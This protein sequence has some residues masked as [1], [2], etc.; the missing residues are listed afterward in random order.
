MCRASSPRAPVARAGHGPLP[1]ALARD[2]L[3]RPVRR[4]PVRRDGVR[5]PRRLRPPPGRVGGV[6]QPLRPGRTRV[7]LRPRPDEAPSRRRLLGGGAPRGDFA[8]T[9]SKEAGRIS[10]A[11]AAF[12]DPDRSP[13]RPR[14]RS[15]VVPPYDEWV[16]TL[17]WTARPPD[18]ALRPPGSLRPPLGGGGRHAHGVGEGAGP[19]HHHRRR[20][21]RSRSGRRHHA[22]PGR[23]P[24]RGRPS[25]R[26]G[27]GDRCAPAGT[28]QRHR[29]WRAARVRGTKTRVPIP[30]RELG[31][32]PVACRP[33]AGR[34]RPPR[35]TARRRGGCREGAVAGRG[36]V[37]AEP[38]A[39]GGR[40]HAECAQAVAV[41]ALVEAAHLRES[42]PSWDPYR[43]R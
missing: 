4:R 3:P 9:S 37:R 35:P 36:G 21:A 27:V 30:L 11:V 40:G 25:L 22:Q 7:R 29:P 6:E 32:V 33:S 42:P 1:V 26:W 16:E 38:D 20:G 17:M 12:A 43:V 23:A 41:H 28:A 14:P 18:R 8:V 13:L 34:P 15:D 10:M 24:P 31:A 39:D 5:L 19:R 2:R